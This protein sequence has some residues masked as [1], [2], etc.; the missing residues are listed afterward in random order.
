[1]LT[2][3]STDG[4]ATW[5][6]HV[7]TLAFSGFLSGQVK[8]KKIVAYPRAEFS[9]LELAPARGLTSAYLLIHRPGVELRAKLGP[10][11]R[12]DTFVVPF[13]KDE[14]VTQFVAAVNGGVHHGAPSAPVTMPV[15]PATT[16]GWAES[17]SR[18]GNEPEPADMPPSRAVPALGRSGFGT[19]RVAAAVEPPA[20]QIDSWQVAEENAAAWMRYWGHSDAACTPA[21]ADGGIDVRART[22]VA[23]VKFEAAQ[24]GAPA[25]Q[26]LVGARGLDHSLTLY[27]FSGAG[28]ARPAVDYAE[29]MGIALFKYD[30]LG[31]M[32]P[33]SSAASTAIARAAE[34]VRLSEER[35]SVRLSAERESV[36]LSAERLR[37]LPAVRAWLATT[38]PAQPDPPGWFG[39]NWSL[40]LALWFLL[41]G[42]WNGVGYLRGAAPEDI[43]WRAPLILLLV[44]CALVLLWRHLGRKRR[45]REVGA[46]SVAPVVWPA[47]P[48]P[49]SVL[50]AVLGSPGV[51]GALR[52][53]NRIQ[54]IKHYRTANPGFG[55]V[56]S[57]R[58]IDA[59][60]AD[61]RFAADDRS[62]SQ[63]G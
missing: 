49:A 51:A 24:V 52:A 18:G 32:T 19:Q 6:G 59:V 23:Q 3:K 36:R 39:R 28:F 33:V 40:L 20:R 25:V 16:P 30:L 55:L 41:G 60:S 4:T 22:A 29:M 43:D 14:A 47:R 62:A 50:A 45:A 35:E 42:L 8:R 11:K 38:P 54:A 9:W 31:R 63:D 46:A 61:S 26:R 17:E 10:Q 1:M 53:R 7:L 34:S 57:K 12:L 21:G 58:L 37:A 56:E 13:G 15:A 5:D 44:G 48:M 2:L 27:F